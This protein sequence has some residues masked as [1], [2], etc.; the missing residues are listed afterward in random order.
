[1]EEQIRELMHQLLQKRLVTKTERKYKKPKPGKKRLVKF[2]KTLE[3]VQVC[4]AHM[5]SYLQPLDVPV[6]PAPAAP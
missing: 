2:P 6:T 4:L 5:S 1:M 3:L